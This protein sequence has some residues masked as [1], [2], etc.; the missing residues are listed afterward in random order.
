MSK[1]LTISNFQDLQVNFAGE[2]YYDNSA[3][4]QAQKL[5]YSTDAS[6]YQEKPIA[7]AVPKN[8]SDIQILIRFA[9]EHQ[10]TLIPRSAGTSLA[11]QVVGKGIIV[12]ISKYLNQ[13][14][15]VNVEERWVRV[16]PGV[17]RDDLNAFSNPTVYFLVQKPP[18]LA[19]R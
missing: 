16:Q 10:V 13:V 11:G 2:L 5:I 6:V 8:A 19:V 4:H 3:E 14:L 17:I 18:L 9:N 1:K 15:E 7:V 12:D